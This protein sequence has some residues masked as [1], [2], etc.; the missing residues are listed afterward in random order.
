MKN[1]A[2]MIRRGFCF[3]SVSDYLEAASAAAG[4]AAAP[5]EAAAG[6]GAGTA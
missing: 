5:S 2:G 1:P 6:D 4:E 3:A